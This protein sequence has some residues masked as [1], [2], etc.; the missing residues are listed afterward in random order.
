MGVDARHALVEPPRLGC[1]AAA[2]HRDP[3]PAALAFA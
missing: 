1:A 2:D 3:F